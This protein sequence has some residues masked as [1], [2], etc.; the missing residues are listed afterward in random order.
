[1]GD[2]P[3]TFEPIIGFI[4]EWDEEII[5]GM[6]SEE[7]LNQQSKANATRKAY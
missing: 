7:S 1:M 3:E 6:L 5:H 2:I 4:C